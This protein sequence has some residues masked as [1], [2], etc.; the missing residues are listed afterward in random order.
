GRVLFRSQFQ[1][2]VGNG[3]DALWAQKYVFES[4]P[5]VAGD[6]VFVI[7]N[8]GAAI[9][10]T[11]QGPA[12]LFDLPADPRKLDNRFI[13]GS[14]I[15]SW[16]PPGA[17]T[18]RPPGWMVSARPISATPVL[19]PPAISDDLMVIATGEGITAYKAGKAPIADANR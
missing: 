17:E 6:H 1:T 13:A 4:S 2:G 14:D 5:V 8:R 18:T 15:G 7:G 16:P 19:A 12:A 9:P 11:Q 10:L 3:A